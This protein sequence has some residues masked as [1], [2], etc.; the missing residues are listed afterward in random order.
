[1]DRDIGYMSWS[2]SCRNK[3]NQKTT[4]STLIETVKDQYANIKWT[5]AAKYVP[6]DELIIRNH[7]QSIKETVNN[8]AFQALTEIHKFSEIKDGAPRLI[9]NRVPKS[10]YLDGALG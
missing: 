6:V 5:L 2:L 8:N 1:M 3:H 4:C 10:C 7:T 9:L